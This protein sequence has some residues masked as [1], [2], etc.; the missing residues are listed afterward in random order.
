MRFQFHKQVTGQYEAGMEVQASWDGSNP[1][2]IRIQTYEME[3]IKQEIDKPVDNDRF[4]KVKHRNH[5]Y[6]FNIAARRGKLRAVADAS[7]N[8]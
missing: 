7:Y 8:R 3:V 4:I 6:E 2:L 5:K 1:N